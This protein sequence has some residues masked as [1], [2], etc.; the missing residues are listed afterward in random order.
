MSQNNKNISKLLSVDD[1]RRMWGLLNTPDQKNKTLPITP[2]ELLAISNETATSRQFDIYPDSVDDIRNKVKSSQ[3][4]Y[5]GLYEATEGRYDNAQ[6][7][8]TFMQITDNRVTIARPTMMTRRIRLNLEDDC[9]YDDAMSLKIEAQ[10]NLR[11]DVENSSY[12][13]AQSSEWKSAHFIDGSGLVHG[14]PVV[15]VKGED[16]DDFNEI[17]LAHMTDVVK[18]S[19]ELGIKL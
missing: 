6:W 18:R 12:V 11:A 16:S 15:A 8:Q 5:N 3:S 19:Q 13:S 14:F 17:L 1:L 10:F 9:A 7:N 4:V 2:K